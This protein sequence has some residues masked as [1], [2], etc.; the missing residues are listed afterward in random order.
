MPSVPLSLLRLS[1]RSVKK[2]RVFIQHA[3]KI[4]IIIRRP[5]FLFGIGIAGSIFFIMFF[6]IPDETSG[7]FQYI[8]LL[9]A[10]VLCAYLA[11]YAVKW[12]V[13]VEQDKITVH[14]PLKKY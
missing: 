6:L 10:S 1:F 7:L 11:I 12:N 4:S 9:G 2:K 3:I 14:H 5:K 13:V 8:F